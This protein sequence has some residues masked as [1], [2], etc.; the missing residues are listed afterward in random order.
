MMI[1]TSEAWVVST[2]QLS[3]ALCCGRGFDPAVGATVQ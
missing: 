3:L 1:H 2:T